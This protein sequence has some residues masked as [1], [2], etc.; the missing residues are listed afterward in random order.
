MDVIMTER[1]QREWVR[2]LGTT[3]A[4]RLRALRDLL[5]RANADGMNAADRA[6]CR[7]WI[8]KLEGHDAEE[9]C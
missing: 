9:S 1:E 5:R 3:D 7:C 8:T 6:I 2:L 4:A